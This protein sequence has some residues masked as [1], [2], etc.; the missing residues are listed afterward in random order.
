MRGITNPIL[1]TTMSATEEPI[2]MINVKLFAAYLLQY[3]G[4]LAYLTI[5]RN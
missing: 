4:V 5:H 2:Q 1:L 3:L